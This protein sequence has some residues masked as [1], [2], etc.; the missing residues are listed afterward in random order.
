MRRIPQTLNLPRVPTDPKVARSLKSNLFVVLLEYLNPF[1]LPPTI[2]LPVDWNI[3]RLV[4]RNGYAHRRSGITMVQGTLCA[5]GNTSG[6]SESFYP[7]EEDSVRLS[8]HGLALKLSYYASWIDQPRRND[9]KFVYGELDNLPP[10]P[11]VIFK[12]K[13]DLHPGRVKM[14]VIADLVI[15]TCR[16]YPGLVILIGAPLLATQLRRPSRSC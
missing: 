9:T 15:E 11:K 1:R 16:K 3:E 7:I 5:A 8:P 14:K 6:G 2:T 10:V 12:P 13:F 4:I